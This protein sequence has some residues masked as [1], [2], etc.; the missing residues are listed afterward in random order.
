M[1]RQLRAGE[2]IPDGPPRRYLNK[3]TG[4]V[5]LRWKV[6]VR[7]YVEVYE[8]RVADGRV[9]DAQQVHHRNHDRADNR[10]E[11]LKPVTVAEHGEHHR[12]VDH[13]WII[14]EY[15]Y[16]EA[17][18]T[19]ADDLGVHPATVSRILTQH[20]VPRHPIRRRRD[21]DPDEVTRRLRAGEPAAQVASD[22]RCSPNLI[23]TIRKAAGIP[24]RRPGRPRSVP[25]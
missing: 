12:A 3:S 14:C 8:H 11:N 20:A 23:H 15:M 10:P 24:P 4:Y 13:D 2:P 5:R 18:D 22:L 9:V 25:G 1:I 16:G 17:M 7:Q 6:G 19:I 21:V